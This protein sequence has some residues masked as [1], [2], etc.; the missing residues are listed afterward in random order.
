MWCLSG[1]LHSKISS[2]EVGK[3]D[4]EM[5]WF[6]KMEGWSF[7]YWL[8]WMRQSVCN[9]LSGDINRKM[10]KQTLISMRGSRFLSL[11][12][13][14][15]RRQK[16]KKETAVKESRQYT[17]PYFWLL[18]FCFCT[19]VQHFLVGFNTT[20]ILLKLHMSVCAAPPPKVGLQNGVLL[21]WFKHQFDSSKQ[22]SF[23]R[24]YPCCQLPQGSKPITVENLEFNLGKMSSTFSVVRELKSGN[25]GKNIKKSGKSQGM[26]KW[27]R[28]NWDS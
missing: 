17:V 21:L 12:F 7:V 20:S 13:I 28:E 25:F 23:Q 5:Y 19:R 8:L 11:P 4:Y 26:F 10:V 2:L 14:K 27:V 18:K 3:Y 24:Y 16:E 22:R 15:H 9:K 6:S 1:F